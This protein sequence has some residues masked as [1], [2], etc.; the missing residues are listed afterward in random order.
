M[1]PLYN[2]LS[3]LFQAKWKN[4]L[5]QPLTLEIKAG[6]IKWFPKGQYEFMRKHLADAVY[7]SRDA[8]SN[9]EL[10]Y[11]GIYKEI[12]DLKL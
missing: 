8:I 9:S 5:N 10:Q 11:E 6:E 12:S 2:P 7:N 4:E 1:R 3:N